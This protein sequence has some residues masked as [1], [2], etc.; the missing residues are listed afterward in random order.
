[1][2]K[3]IVIFLLSVSSAFSQATSGL[4]NQPAA[5]VQAAAKAIPNTLSDLR[6]SYT[7]LSAACADAAS[8]GKTLLVSRAW[9]GIATSTCSAKVAAVKGSVIQPA[10]GAIVHLVTFTTVDGNYKVFDTSVAGAG[11]IVLDQA[12]ALPEW[13]GAVG[14]NPAVDS[15]P[16]IASA[17][18]AMPSTDGGIHV[19]GMVELSA[20]VTYY[21]K[22]EPHG[23][24]CHIALNIPTS[25]GFTLKGN[26]AT[27]NTDNLGRSGTL[28]NSTPPLRTGQTCNGTNW[29]CQYSYEGEC[30]FNCVVMNPAAIGALTITVADGTK[31]KVGHAIYYQGGANHNGNDEPNAEMNIVVAINGNA[32]TLKYPVQKTFPSGFYD[33]TWPTGAV[34]VDYLTTKNLEI[35]D[36]NVEGT[37]GSGIGT[38]G[39]FGTKLNHVL[40]NVLRSDYLNGYNRDMYWGHTTWIARLNSSSGSAGGLF[41]VAR[42]SADVTVEFS[43]FVG[44]RPTVISFIGV[45]EGSYNFHAL[46]NQ[47][48]GEGEVGI[49]SG[50][51]PGTGFEVAD[52]DW[53][54]WGSWSGQG[55]LSTICCGSQ[56]INNI[57]ISNNRFH[58][59]NTVEATMNV[60]GPGAIIQGNHIDAMNAPVNTV[61]LRGMRGGQF[62][63]NTINS[64]G[65]G[66][67]VGDNA[68]EFQFTGN[69]INGAGVPNSNCITFQ[70]PTAAT[71]APNIIGNNCKNFVNGI[72]TNSPVKK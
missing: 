62:I 4:Q 38:I 31:F 46:H 26:G 17:L 53:Y 8:Q 68:V 44:Y 55:L 25:D 47:F 28:I 27:F 51:N 64:G 50:T 2:T 39:T 34:D 24:C 5:V 43:N 32:L 61:F 36:L 10:S 11:S 71:A 30:L 40:V 6:A 45:N 42:N 37:S 18:R 56:P 70:T 23:A 7:T 29:D 14:N 65:S 16:G 66:I 20:G 48:I 67:R 1:M 33:S 69:N 41:Q 52:N 59:Y 49:S 22:S 57:I 54:T 19:H 9:T 35:D 15:A 13:F 12:Y 60:G 58:N 3:T 21:L 63:G 72:R